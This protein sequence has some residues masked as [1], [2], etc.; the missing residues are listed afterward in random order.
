MS[1][2]KITGE[3]GKTTTFNFKFDNGLPTKPIISPNYDIGY[4]KEKNFY[5]LSMYFTE[6][7]L[8]QLGN[9][10]IEDVNYSEDLSE[11]WLT[12]NE[13]YVVFENL[14]DKIINEV[15]NKKL[16]Y[17]FFKEDKTFIDGVQLE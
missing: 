11:L 10:E 9:L 7:N 15:E 17:Y 16:K 1:E 4:S 6:E 5:A 12:I 14:T 2:F 13:H 8:K 3:S